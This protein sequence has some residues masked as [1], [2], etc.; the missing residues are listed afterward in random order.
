MIKMKIMSLFK[1]LKQIAITFT[2]VYMWMA[3]CHYLAFN[4]NVASGNAC[5]F[6]GVAVILF[7]LIVKRIETY[8][9][10]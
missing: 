4:V 10:H 3:S 5:F 6:G 2:L 7:S 9:K 8:S 1:A